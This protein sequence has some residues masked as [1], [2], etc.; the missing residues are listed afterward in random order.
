MFRIKILNNL[1]NKVLNHQ[2]QDKQE[3]LEIRNNQIRLGN[4]LNSVC[5]SEGYKKAFEYFEDQI[6]SLYRNKEVNFD[7]IQGIESVFNYFESG[8]EMSALAAKELEEFKDE[9]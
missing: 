1:K 2:P 7:R 5:E 6:N 8:K 4:Q 3:W 9:I